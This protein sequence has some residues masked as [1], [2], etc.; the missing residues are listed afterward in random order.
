M[1]NNFYKKY[2]KYKNKYNELKNMIGGMFLTPSK[3]N[4]EELQPVDIISLPE[5][6]FQRYATMFDL[7]IKGNIFEELKESIIDDIFMNKYNENGLL[8]QIKPITLKY[9]NLFYTIDLKITEDFYVYRSVKKKIIK[10]KTLRNYLPFSTVND[11]NKLTDES[12]YGGF[13]QEIVILKIL[14]PR[15]CIY[16]FIGGGENEITIQPGTL[17]INNQYIHREATGER[18]YIVYDCSFIPY[19]L[20]EALHLIEQNKQ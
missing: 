8:I 14:I 17:M 19:S 20:D 10:S 1:S 11:I 3:I 12:S 15:D 9:V 18:Y 7:Y 16:L 2:M 6:K 13:W 5:A 4:I